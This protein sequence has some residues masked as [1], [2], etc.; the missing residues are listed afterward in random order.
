MFQCPQV[1]TVARVLR[2]DGQ[3]YLIAG[4]VHKALASITAAQEQ[5]ELLRQLSDVHMLV[6]L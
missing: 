3:V 5:C 2:L 6:S 4:L 1:D